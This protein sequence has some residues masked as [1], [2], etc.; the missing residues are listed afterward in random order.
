MSK[1][2]KWILLETMVQRF[3][4]ISRQS[5]P[6]GRSEDVNQYQHGSRLRNQIRLGNISVKPQTNTRLINNGCR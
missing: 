5:E 3:H 6:A 4:C 1:A 2:W